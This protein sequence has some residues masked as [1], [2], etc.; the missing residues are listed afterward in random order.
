MAP[1]RSMYERRTPPKIVPWAFVSFGIRVTRIAG[2]RTSGEAVAL[3]SRLSRVG[4]AFSSARS[5]NSLRHER[6]RPHPRTPRR[7]VDGEDNPDPASPGRGRP[8][9][10]RPDRGDDG[11]RQD[12]ARDRPDRG[13]AEEGDSGP[14]DRPEGG[15]GEPAA[16][17]PQP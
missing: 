1:A 3:I 16:R 15:P 7:S 17:L 10:A 8:D 14:G 4:L 11:E 9:D 6:N 12:R 2:E 5:V 13:A